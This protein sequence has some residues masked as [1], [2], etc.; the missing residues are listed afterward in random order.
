MLT[1][2]QFARNVKTRDGSGEN[3]EF[4]VRLPGHESGA[5][6]WLPIDAQ[7]SG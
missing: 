1:P 5:P 6:V 4:A 7:V 3:V 2:E